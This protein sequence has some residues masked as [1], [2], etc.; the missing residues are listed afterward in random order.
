MS[1]SSLSNRPRSALALWALVLPGAALGQVRTIPDTRPPIAELVARLD[2]E[3]FAARRQA[4][5][6]L[7]G[8]GDLT[9]DVAE[10]LATEPDLSPEQ[11][12]RLERLALEV[13]GRG[14]RAAVGIRFPPEGDTGV[15]IQEVL[16]GFPASDV[17]RAGDRIVEADGLAITQQATFRAAI[18]SHSPGEVM[19][20]KL[21]REG[22]TLEVDVPLDSFG[23]LVGAAAPRPGDLLAAWTLRRSRDGASPTGEPIV[24]ERRSPGDESVPPEPGT[25]A[26]ESAFATPDGPRGLRVGGQVRESIDLSLS[27]LAAMDASRALT[28]EDLQAGGAADLSVQISLLRDR[29]GL[30]LDD[31]ERI[32]DLIEGRNLDAAGRA[33]MRR[34]L[35]DERQMLVVIEEQIRMLDEARR[36]RP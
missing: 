34:R 29:R 1:D 17:L 30:I 36:A 3:V 19:A 11:K 16:P 8:R 7:L 14:P 33:M 26:W 18:L 4:T 20:M 15:R 35:D 21:V 31:I 32:A 9:L 12:L 22:E 2:A 27:Q 24:P 6:D 28:L 10:W 23:R 5:A 13:F 25:R